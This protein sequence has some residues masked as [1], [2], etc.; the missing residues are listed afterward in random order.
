MRRNRLQKKLI[1]PQVRVRSIRERTKPNEPDLIRSEEPST[2]IGWSSKFHKGNSV[3]RNG[4]LKETWIETGYQQVNIW[5]EQTTTIEND[6]LAQMYRHDIAVQVIKPPSKCDAISRF[7]E[8]NSK[9]H[10]MVEKERVITDWN[11][12]PKKQ[13][14]SS[15]LFPTALPSIQIHPASAFTS[16]CY[17]HGRNQ[18]NSQRPS[19]DH[20]QVING[21]HSEII[22]HLNLSFPDRSAQTWTAR[23]T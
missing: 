8:R 14:F 23:K 1:F 7:S 19:A 9:G 17:Q 12:H 4:E 22:P 5:N 6:Q 15:V 11:R 13:V 2:Q 21:L 20:H 10:E 3:Q 16:P 18:F